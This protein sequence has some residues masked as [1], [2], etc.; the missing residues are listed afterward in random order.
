MDDSE[1]RR[2]VEAV[3]LGTPEPLSAQRVAGVIPYA[4]P[5]KIKKLVDELNAEYIAQDRAFEIVEVA[6]GYQV[7]TLPE[8]ATQ[9]QQIQPQR[10][11]RL[12][13]AALETLAIVAYKQPVTRGDV[14]DVR[15]VDAGAVM[16]S[17]LERKL[18]KLAGHKEVPGRPMLYG[19]TRRFLEVFSLESLEDLP[20]LRQLEELAPRAESAED[21]GA[22]QSD[23]DVDLDTDLPESV[24]PVGPAFA[25]T[26]EAAAAVFDDV[27]P[28]GKPH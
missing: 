5:A 4:K 19:T 25:P 24:A 20:S 22:T 17:L 6:G 27:E 1:K 28:V 2:I 8:F 3:I 9:L 21:G 13:K 14:E 16:R 23:L 7:R 26:V 12:S 10:P 18:V 15:G 11:L